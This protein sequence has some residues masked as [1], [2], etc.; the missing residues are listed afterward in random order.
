MERTLPVE[1][2]NF[3]MEDK[4]MFLLVNSNEEHEFTEILMIS[5]TLIKMVKTG[6]YGKAIERWNNLPALN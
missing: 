4:R 2:M 5:Y 3:G 6:I 1:V